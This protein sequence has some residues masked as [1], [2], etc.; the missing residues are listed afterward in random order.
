M[1]SKLLEIKNIKK[2]YVDKTTTIEAVKEA[3]FTLNK[4]E[5]F[6]LLGTNGAGKTTLSSIVASLHPPTSGE[7]IFEGQSIYKDLIGYRKKLGYCPQKH[8]LGSSLTVEEILTFSGRFYGMANTEITE[9]VN[10]V[11]KKLDLEKYRNTTP[12][13]LS[14]GYK[15]RVLIARSI[16]HNPSLL[17]LDEPTAAMDPHIRRQIWKIIEDLKKQGVTIILT[18]HYLDEAEKL[19]DRVCFMKDG[20]IIAIETPKD[21]LAKF[22]KQNLEDVF[23]HMVDNEEDQE[24]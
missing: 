13:K 20:K 3:T 23:L 18:T 1:N 12:D 11:I 24:N 5:V 21:F 2:T 6:G 8:N 7:V 4:G 17:I 16:I 14:G 15:Q 22:G 9:S 19:S 10:A